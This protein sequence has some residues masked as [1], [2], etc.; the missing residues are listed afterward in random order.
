MDTKC[1]KRSEKRQTEREGRR[2]NPSPCPREKE[3][4]TL[5]RD[6]KKAYK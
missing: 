2:N 6:E 3:R 4:E 1:V 5:K